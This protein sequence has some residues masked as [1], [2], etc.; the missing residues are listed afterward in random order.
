M[1]TIHFTLKVETGDDAAQ[2]HATPHDYVLS[3]LD[4]VREKLA[5][6]VNSC[7]IHDEN[8]NR[9]GDYWLEVER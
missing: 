2:G 3:V 8:G 4:R 5:H 7:P 6:G 1:R 9:V